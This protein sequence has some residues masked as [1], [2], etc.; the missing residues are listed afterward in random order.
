MHAD[1]HKKNRSCTSNMKL[2]RRNQ[3][4]N[5]AD[6]LLNSPFL[7]HEEP[8]PQH[9]YLDLEAE[10]DALDDPDSYSRAIASAVHRF[11]WFSQF[12]ISSAQG[13][14]YELRRKTVRAIRRILFSFLAGRPMNA[15]A[16]RVATSRR[17]VYA[18]IEREIYSD[19]GELDTWSELGLIRVW[20]LPR[21]TFGGTQLDDG[22]RFE[23]EC[24]AVVCLLCH[25]LVGHV[26]LFDRLYDS[27]L[28]VGESNRFEPYSYRN[29]SVRGH[30][31]SH[32]FFGERP[33]PNRRMMI[34][35]GSGGRP[36][37]YT[38]RGGWMDRVELTVAG[39]A[40]NDQD[41]I[42]P[43]T[44]DGSPTEGEVREHYLGL[45]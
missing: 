17:T 13:I 23:E 39:I 45:L 26:S 41:R 4:Q 30:L 31:I 40:G 21:V 9:I 20:D 29:N 5:S 1:T 22:I 33:V 10:P 25:R 32:F 16:K 34:D 11:P 15:V 7:R 28:V 37:F 6:H 19:Y 14:D 12:H 44:E 35:Y 18:T 38:A 2:F 42:L 3:E 36:R 8:D 27:S 24:A 43:V